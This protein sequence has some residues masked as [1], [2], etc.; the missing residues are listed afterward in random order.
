MNI[1]RFKN[2]LTSPRMGAVVFLVAGVVALWTCALVEFTQENK[3]ETY[4]VNIR[5]G[6]VNYGTHS[7]ATIPLVSAPQHSSVAPL[8]SGNTVRSYAYSGHASMT[9]NVSSGRIRTTSVGK[10]NTSSVAAGTNGGSASSGVSSGVTRSMASNALGSSYSI[11]AVPVPT[12]AMV[13]RSYASE[14]SAMGASSTAD[15]SL[16]GKTSLGGKKEDVVSSTP[17][18]PDQPGQPPIPLGNTPWLLMVL[19]A[20]GYGVKRGLSPC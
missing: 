17:G 20:A 9:S 15:E 11:S 3:R 1:S 7:S 13:S 5:P 6:I 18:T 4:A 2:K 8:I 12:L 14:V 19:L 16:S 10:A